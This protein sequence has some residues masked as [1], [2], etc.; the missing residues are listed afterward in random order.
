MQE[1]NEA[2]PD[3]IRITLRMTSQQRNSLRHP[4]GRQRIPLKPQ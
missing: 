1:K 4:V 2:R 3:G